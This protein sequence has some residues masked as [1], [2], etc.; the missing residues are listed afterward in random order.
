MALS[1]QG[2]RSKPVSGLDLRSGNL[3][4]CDNARVLVA[5]PLAHGVVR[6]A[7]CCGLHRDKPGARGRRARPR[8]ECEFRRVGGAAQACRECGCRAS[9]EYVQRNSRQFSSVR[10][11]EA[12]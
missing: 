4:E 10:A 6:R 12:R 7:R 8:D 1:G 3:V 5:V 9:A 11:N 2:W